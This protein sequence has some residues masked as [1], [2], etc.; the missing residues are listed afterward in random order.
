MGQEFRSMI[1]I[2]IGGSPALGLNH[3]T[4]GDHLGNKCQ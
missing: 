3:E 1:E 2:Y 4:R